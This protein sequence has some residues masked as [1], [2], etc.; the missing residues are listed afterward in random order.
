MR[1]AIFGAVA[2]PGVVGGDVVLPGQRAGEYEAN[3]ALLEHVGGAIAATRLQTA[4][5]RLGEPERVDVV[6][7]RLGGVTDVE[8]EVIDAVDRHHVGGLRRGSR[9]GFCGHACNDPL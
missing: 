7:S 2:V 1:S 5:R 9:R 4:V 6:V 3:P 8:L